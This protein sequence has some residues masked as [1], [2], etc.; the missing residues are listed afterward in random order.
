L[1]GYILCAVSALAFSVKGILAKMLYAEGLDPVTVLALRFSM[2]LPLFWLTLFFHPSARV[3][4]RDLVI[5]VLSGLVGL[6]LSALADFEG[7]IHVDA[8]IERVILY[9]YPTMVL[10]LSA[11]FFKERLR[12]H[13]WL[14][15]A[16]V[17][18][19]LALTLRLHAGGLRA[20]LKGAALILFSAMVYSFSYIITESLSKRVSAVKISAYAATAAAAA[21]LATWRGHT[22]PRGASAWWLL[23]LLAVVSTY[24]PAL[25]LALGIERIGASRA[26]L[27]GFLGPLSTAVLAAV[28]LGERMDAAQGAGMAIV[29]IGV[30]FISLKRSGWM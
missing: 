9:T 30:L 15:L 10:L 19:G 27:V 16:F 29:V 1:A 8:S 4:K 22:V 6:Y 23:S 18:A 24:I 21:F 11:A 5:L 28:L 17:Y 13:D 7:L 25:T 20:E 2:A 12:A 14:A 3:G 26:A